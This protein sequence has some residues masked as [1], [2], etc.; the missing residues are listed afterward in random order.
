[1]VTI[2]RV[3]ELFEYNPATG[4]FTRLIKVKRH[5]KGDVAGCLKKDGY[6]VIKID[7]VIYYAHRLAYFYM[8]G[9]WFDGETDHKDLNRSNNKWD[10]I[11][12]STYSQN[13]MNTGLWKTTTSGHKG[14][15]WDKS[16]KKWRVRMGVNNKVLNFGSYESFEEACVVRK[17]KEIEFF[18]EF[19]R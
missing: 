10:N 7:G 1:M 5:N 19:S 12:E 2:E 3:K 11:R 8:T 18:G 6:V 15:H 13:Q 4:L 17:N 9:R 14:V 16:S